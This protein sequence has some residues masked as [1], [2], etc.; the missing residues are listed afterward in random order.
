MSDQ[1]NHRVVVTSRGGPDVLQLIEEPIPEPGPGDVRVKVDAA[2]V[3]GFD[4]LLRSISLPGNPKPPFTPGED[5]AGVIDAL[6]PG[7][8][9]HTVGEPVAGWTFGDQGGYAEYVCGPAWRFVGIPEGLT[10]IEAVA[11]VINYLTAHLY[12]HHTA[13]VQSGERVLVHGAAGGL[14]TAL[15]QLGNLAGLDVYGT[16]STHNQG[17]VAYLGATPIDY[18]TED[19][20]ARIRALTGDGVDAVFDTV[21]GVRQLWRSYRCIRRGGRLIPIGS[22][23]I[24]NGGRKLIPFGLLTAVTLKLVP[25]GRGVPLSPNMMTFPAAHHDWYRQTLAELLGL[26]AAGDIRPMIGGSIPLCE[27][28][29]AHQLLADGRHAGKIVLTTQP[30]G[31]SVAA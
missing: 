18:R 10:P 21:S 8:D 15:V 26:A 29:S 23:G 28:A 1:R 13:E 24:S 9:G 2:G 12:L 16:A 5:I 27:A 17:V 7:V 14:G 6:G 3:S 19:F 11:V 31:G 30:S 22:V 20:V 25:D 4:V